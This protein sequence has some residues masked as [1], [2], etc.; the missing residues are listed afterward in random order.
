MSNTYKTA[1]WPVRVLR[2]RATVVHH[3]HSIG[4]CD[5]DGPVTLADFDAPFARGRCHVDA[6]LA[7]W[8]TASFCGCRMCTDF[9]GR[10]ADRRRSR[11]VAQRALRA[12]M[13][14]GDWLADVTPSTR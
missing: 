8:C 2:E 10:R 1:P 11:H 6:T 7:F 3:D 9:W 12:M 5:I 4:C 14:S 13:V